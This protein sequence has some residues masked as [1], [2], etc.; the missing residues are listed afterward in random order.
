MVIEVFEAEVARGGEAP[1]PIDGDGLSIV[2]LVFSL[3]QSKAVILFCSE[4]QIKKTFFAILK[5]DQNALNM[6][7]CFVLPVTQTEI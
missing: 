5:F 2:I 6:K 7:N 3:T 4:S 1:G